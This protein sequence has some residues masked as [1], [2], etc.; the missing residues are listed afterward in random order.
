MSSA[1]DRALADVSRMRA[2]ARAA[3]A[4]TPADLLASG[5][6]AGP[7]GQPTIGNTKEFY[8]HNRGWVYACVNAIAK[9]V[10][11]QT[12][13]VGRIRA[14]G[15]PNS[16]KLVKW[17]T[18]ATLPGR[19][20]D[21]AARIEELPAH[22][23]LELLHDPSAIHTAFTLLYSFVASLELTGRSF[24]WATEG[25]E[26]RELHPIPTSWIRGYEGASRIESWKVQPPGIGEPFDIPAAQ[27][28]YVF[29]PDPRDPFAALGPLQAAAMPVTA[30]EQI[31]ASQ[32]AMFRQG[33]MPKFALK[34]GRLPGTNGHEGSRPSL[35][36]DQRKQ[37]ITAIQQ[38]YAGT[39]NHHGAIIIDGLIEGI[40][41]LSS[42]AAE[43]DFLNS[44]RDVK[45]R[46]LQ[47]FGVNPI[48]LGEIEGAN[49]ASAVVAEQNFLDNKI[50]PLCELLSQALT[51]WLGPIFAAAGE[52][53]VI[54][55]EPPLARDAEQHVKEMDMLARHGAVTV[56]ELRAAF[57]YPPAE[58]FLSGEMAPRA[59]DSIADAI[60]SQV[61]DQ[62]ARLGVD[63]MSAGYFGEP[64]TNG[65]AHT[66]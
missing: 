36:S 30:D 39:A 5:R 44:G 23:L 9:R 2:S 15:I 41:R 38:A 65:R 17:W 61:S 25:A 4:S 28:V 24:L 8:E 48:V 18:H 54:W 58:V 60:H 3:L 42:T 14:A 26:G 52:K 13:H 53:L 22:D 59:A 29:Y 32:L 20:K 49:R 12:I 51:E 35:T 63:A 43:M 31:Q 19:M 7:F 11:G 37:L 50:G 56:D 66:H 6:P 62:L 16:S 45:S 64:S 33:I 34:A 27:M 21:L 10:A 57:G 1:I 47:I 46:I 55:I 40:E